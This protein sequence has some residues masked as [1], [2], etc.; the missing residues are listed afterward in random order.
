MEIKSDF[1]KEATTYFEWEAY[2]SRA[3]FEGDFVDYRYN[4]LVENVWDML[5]YEMEE[6]G[7]VEESILREMEWY[8]GHKD[9]I[10]S[11]VLDHILTDWKERTGYDE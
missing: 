3:E 4:E 11:S 6:D 1:M 2:K 7:L 9:D 8:I 10:M 5:R